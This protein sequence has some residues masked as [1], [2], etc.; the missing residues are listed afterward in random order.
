M[1]LSA[2]IKF[3]MA[4]FVLLGQ[5]RRLTIEIRFLIPSQEVG[6]QIRLNLEAIGWPILPALCLKIQGDAVIEEDRLSVSEIFHPEKVEISYPEHVGCH[7][8]GEDNSI[9]YAIR[10]VAL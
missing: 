10:Q 4:T 8:L 1:G 6:W 3:Q 2:P 5:V 9:N 7:P